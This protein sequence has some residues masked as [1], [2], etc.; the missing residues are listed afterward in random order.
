L[1]EPHALTAAAEDYK[2]HLSGVTILELETV[3]DKSGGAARITLESETGRIACISVLDAR[4]LNYSGPCI[5]ARN[6]TM[7]PMVPAPA[8]SSLVEGM[9]TA[10]VE[11]TLRQLC[12]IASAQRDRRKFR[13][14]L[15]ELREFLQEHRELLR[16]MSDD[17]FE[18]LRRVWHS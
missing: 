1:L 18:A 10:E 8:K 4:L 6:Y 12:A 13:N 11:N 9:E 5:P 2:V 17:T 7:G 14:V 16:S 3:P 15:L